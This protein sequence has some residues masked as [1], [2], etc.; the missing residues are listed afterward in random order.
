LRLRFLG[1]EARVTTKDL[2]VTSYTRELF[3]ED[4]TAINV[5]DSGSALR[6]LQASDSPKIRR[7]HTYPTR[8]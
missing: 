5:F 8:I 4:P 3:G 2:D 1:F 7:F 6:A